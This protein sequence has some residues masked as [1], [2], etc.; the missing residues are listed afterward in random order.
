MP[1]T[2]TYYTNTWS[3][4]APDGATVDFGDVDD[5]IRALKKD[6]RERFAVLLPVGAI[7][8]WSSDIIPVGFVELDGSTL[9]KTDYAALYLF[10]KDGGSA[11][12]YGED[13]TT[14]TL[15]DYRGRFVRGWDHG[16]TI[17]PDAATRADR[18]DTTGGD[19][20]GTIQSD[21][22]ESHHHAYINPFIDNNYGYVYAASG[23]LLQEDGDSYESGGNET[24][25]KNK[26][27]RYLVKALDCVNEA[28]I[29]GV[30]IFNFTRDWNEALPAV[31]DPGGRG[32][33]DMQFLKSDIIAR[34]NFA[35]PVGMI[36][37]WLSDTIPYLWAECNGQAI[38]RTTYSTLFNEIEDFYGPGDGTTTFQIPDL[39]GLFIR[40]NDSSIA[41]GSAGR[42]EDVSL[43]TDRG[44]GTGSDFSGTFQDDDFL[45][46]SHS[47]SYSVSG[48]SSVANTISQGEGAASLLYTGETDYTDNDE[49]GVIQGVNKE[50]RPI[51]KTLRVI[52]RVLPI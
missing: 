48:Y 43:R 36:A 6:L 20:V 25:P 30:K 27:S 52:M 16:A 7:I 24:R 11:C 15:P 17:D 46:H 10:L 19:Q 9:S 23:S 42:D 14:F 33:R 2:P 5:A 4:T 39:R 49:Y 3:N 38:S 50:T 44:D 32:Y 45:S 28:T 21:D 37:F 22:I 13:T 12:I 51:N 40:A 29:D 34:F 35:F 26:Y 41:N 18:G 8:K 31:G 47:L 1:E